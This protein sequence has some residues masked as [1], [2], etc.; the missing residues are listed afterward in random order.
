MLRDVQ[1]SSPEGRLK[2][3]A[4]KQTIKTREFRRGKDGCLL[5]LKRLLYCCFFVFVLLF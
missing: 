1:T 2:G 5:L 3:A 4:T